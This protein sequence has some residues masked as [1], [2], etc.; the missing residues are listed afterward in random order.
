[1]KVRHAAIGA[2][3]SVLMSGCAMPIVQDAERNVEGN[4][5]DAAE[6]VT[7]AR[8][9]MPAA[10]V[11][12]VRVVDAVW[13]TGVARRSEHGRPLPRRLEIPGVTIVHSTPMELFEIGTA[14]TA[15]TGVP[16]SFSADVFGGGTGGQSGGTVP[17]AG[18]P[19]AGELDRMLGQMGL[20]AGGSF[21]NTAGNA[22]GA[23]GNVLRAVASNRTAMKVNHSGKLSDFLN[24]VGSHFGVTWEYANDEIHVYRF[25][26]RTY[27]VHALPSSIDVSSTLDAENK[28]SGA[29]DGESG[30]N[31]SAKSDVSVKI[32]DEISAAVGAIVGDNGRV[33]TS[34]GTGTITVTA[35]ADVTRRVQSY[36]DGQNDRMAKQVAVSVQVLNVSLSDDDDLSLDVQGLFSGSRRFGFNFGN[37]VAETARAAGM[38]GLNFGIIN[39][40]SDFTGSNGVIQ[41]LSE[42]GRVSV[43]STASLTTL[44]GIPAPLQVSNTRNY[45]ESIEVTQTENGV[46]TAM[47][48]GTVTT[49]FNLS[50][51]PRVLEEGRVLMMQF[52]INISELVGENNGFDEFSVEGLTLQLPNKNSRSFVQQT[53][54]PNGSTLVL[55]GFEQMRNQANR[56]GMGKPD[57]M[58]LGGGQEG[59]QQRDIIVVLLTPVL[60][61]AHGPLVS[62]H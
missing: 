45:L 17:A 10:K 42:R 15:A 11:S 20:T 8:Q 25:V 41:A 6:L 46:T 4:R 32:W 60:L 24:Q 19:G 31:Q 35:P 49:G 39:P 43:V 36:I 53:M 13:T 55:T 48:P 40:N 56:R 5:R 54:V 58:F 59:R 38:A 21:G 22:A 26:T 50:I 61:D 30:S 12:P 1:M 57:F 52:G 7:Q 9:P 3:S 37:A 2:L 51:L 23:Q 33:T 14:I 44:N 18:T 62:T 34:V 27:T 47:S 16:V 29:T 28:D